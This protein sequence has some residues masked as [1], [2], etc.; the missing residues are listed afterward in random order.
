MKI[1][2]RAVNDC[3]EAFF[4]SV[5]TELTGFPISYSA[6][7]PEGI[8]GHGAFFGRA[9]LDLSSRRIQIWLNS[10]ISDDAFSHTAA[11]EL[12]HIVLRLRGYYTTS[13]PIDAGP[14]CTQALRPAY[15]LPR[16]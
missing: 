13:I 9:R 15:S 6:V 10:D 8:D 1:L 2:G 11:H 16:P 14:S 5:K 4:A 3:Y 12:A 7:G